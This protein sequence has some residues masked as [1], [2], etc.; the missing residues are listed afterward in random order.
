MET[1]AAPTTDSPAES[2]L[3]SK[4]STR[5]LPFLFVLYVASYLARVNVSFAGLSMKRDLES[6]GLTAERFGLGLG[7]FFLGYLLFEIPSNLVLEKVGARRW[8]ARIMLT[9]GLVAMAMALVRGPKSFYALRILL[10]VAEAGFFPGVILYL[11]YWF[12]PRRRARAVATFMTATAVSGVAGALVSTAILRLDGAANLRGWQW[13]FILEGLPSVLLSAFVL[14]LLPNKPADAPWMSD[15]DRALLA[16]TFAREQATARHHVGDLLPALTHPRVWLLTAVYFM[17]ALG[18]YCVSLWLPL[19]L[20]GAWPGHKDMHYTLLSAIPYAVAA[21]GMV[22]IARS[23]DRTGD[24]RWHSALCLL[25][26][27]IGA[28]GAAASAPLHQP[29]VTLAAFSLVALGIWGA[30]GPFWAMPPAF[31]AG[32]AA[33]GGIALINS[34]GNLGGFLGPYIIGYVKQHT[35]SFTA[36]LWILAALLTTGAILASLIRVHPSHPSAVP[37]IPANP[38]DA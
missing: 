14:L 27:A 5:L 8:I 23:S 35:G 9:W 12:P 29:A 20:A 16:D 30:I 13:L 1:T 2:A 7:L 33:A 15:Q 34:V 38:P 32:T 36:A 31:L 6:H 10:G 18:M 11:T 19:L 21:I 4:I 22:L 25:G 24:R 26:A 37:V 28:A 3:F 17:I